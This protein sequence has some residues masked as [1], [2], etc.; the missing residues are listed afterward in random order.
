[1]SESAPESASAAEGLAN[2]DLQ[3]YARR[4]AVTGTEA[5][6]SPY[7]EATKSL[8][9]ALSIPPLKIAKTALISHRMRKINKIQ[10]RLTHEQSE[11]KKARFLKKI[12]I[13]LKEVGL[14]TN[15]SQYVKSTQ[16]DESPSIATPVKTSP[17]TPNVEMTERAKMVDAGIRD[18]KA[19]FRVD[20]TIR[21]YSSSETSNGDLC[22]SGLRMNVFEKLGLLN[23][24][25][26]SCEVSTLSDSSPDLDHDE[27]D[28]KT[29]GVETE[30][31]EGVSEKVC[32]RKG[33]LDALRSRSEPF[34]GC[35]DNLEFNENLD[36]LAK[37]ADSSNEGKLA[38]EYETQA[39][40]CNGNGSENQ[41]KVYNDSKEVPKRK[42]GNGVSCLSAKRRCKTLPK[43]VVWK[44]LPLPSNKD[45]EKMKGKK[46]FE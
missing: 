10:K 20:P 41:R 44:Y 4:S 32:E 12:H 33:E 21:G 26:S 46:L 15:G 28:P 30:S 38:I 2:T 25:H 6:M 17:M 43:K 39:N 9:N 31:V 1:M 18:W 14:I 36:I 22:G 16:K 19:E 45:Q 40:T 3:E 13:L 29:N 11:R 42:Q 23:E 35:E 7:Q 8:S 37:W 24:E 5:V 27:S 34:S